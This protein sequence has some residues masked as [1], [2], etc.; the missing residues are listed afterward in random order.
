[1]ASA[2]CPFALA[3]ARA[4]AQPDVI[5]IGAGMA[6]LS[7]AR[8][9]NERGA[10]TLVLE[11]RD[12]IGGRIWTSNQWAHVPV[13]L[14]ASWIHGTDGNPLTHLADEAGIARKQTRWDPN[15]VFKPGGGRVVLDDA[16]KL[17][18]TLIEKA[19][20]RAEGRDDDISLSGAVEALP[21]WASLD[22]NKRRL[23]RHII[24]D[25]IELEYAAGWQD[26]SAWSF[27]DSDEYDGAEVVFPDGYGALPA[28]LAKGLSIQTGQ[29]VV[30]IEKA[31]KGVRV[32]TGT[33]SAYQARHVLVTVPLGVL[34]AKRIEFS[35]PLSKDRTTAISA[36]GMGLLNKCC[37]R[38]ERMFWPETGDVFS[39]LGDR[40]GYWSQWLSLSRISGEPL[41]MGFNAGA[42]AREVEALD[43]AGTIAQAM[44][45][46]KSIFGPAV[47]DPVAAQI[48]RWG[49]DPFAL[50]SYS[51]AAVGT[52][53]ETRH[54]FAGTDWNGRLV[55]AGEAV[56]ADHP[57]TVHGAYLSGHEAAEQ[58]AG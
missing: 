4:Q 58:I 11:A 34:K 19:R 49:K 12:R 40:D 8:A 47:P 15:P 20:V 35:H 33:G 43:D 6:G 27:D 28:H 38:F 36:L 53:R 13:D 42:A 57:A 2:A 7:A 31:G 29:V 14:G 41:L 55:F 52:G 46:L 10:A 9:L 51:F 25:N 54:S 24:H 50:G 30:R 56:H 45:A 18:R 32:T 26:L 16:E 3:P 5:I 23:V 39:Y 44:A 21:D 22:E 1:M 17:A 48:S 37:L